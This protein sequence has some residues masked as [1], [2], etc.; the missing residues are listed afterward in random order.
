MG[1]KLNATKC[2]G[3]THVERE[4]TV[5]ALIHYTKNPTNSMNIE[6]VWN[7]ESL[8][9]VTKAQALTVCLHRHRMVN[10]TFHIL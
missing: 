5:G 3:C 9:K 1:L 10:G 8:C 4:G 6:V 7:V 2:V